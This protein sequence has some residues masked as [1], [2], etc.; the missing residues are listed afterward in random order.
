MIRPDFRF[1]ED[2]PSKELNGK[3]V[4]NCLDLNNSNNPGTAPATVNEPNVSKLPLCTAWEGAD[5]QFS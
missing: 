1:S 3:P 4:R 2:D 5:Q